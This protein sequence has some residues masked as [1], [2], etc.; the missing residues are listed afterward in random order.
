M[1]NQTKEQQAVNLAEKHGAYWHAGVVVDGNARYSISVYQ[2]VDMLADHRQQ[3]IE[4][5]VQQ[6]GVLSEAKMAGGWCLASEVREAI[7]TMQASNLMIREQQKEDFARAEQAERE[8]E[9]ARREVLPALQSAAQYYKS[10]DK[11][12]RET[13]EDA[14]RSLK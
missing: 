1:T 12:D 11:A 14:I 10:M 5:L 8:L 4:E 13:I 6:S 7:A 3:I 9:Q 2:L